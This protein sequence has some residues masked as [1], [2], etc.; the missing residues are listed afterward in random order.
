[1]AKD[2]RVLL[3]NSPNK[4]R[5]RLL[6]DDPTPL[7]L[8]EPPCNLELQNKLTD[9]LMSMLDDFAKLETLIIENTEPAVQARLRSQLSIVRERV[10]AYQASSDRQDQTLKEQLNTIERLTEE[11]NRLIAELENQKRAQSLK[12]LEKKNEVLSQS[13]RMLRDKKTTKT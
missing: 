12:T 8:A 2:K 3:S 13:Y 6:S 9:T 11:K 10:E 4:K 5:T 7:I 1:L